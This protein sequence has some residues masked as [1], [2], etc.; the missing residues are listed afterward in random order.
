[1]SLITH[2][3]N[4]FKAVVLV[5]IILIL[6]A[7]L[8]EDTLRIFLPE[9]ETTKSICEVLF[10]IPTFVYM[11]FLYKL[12]RSFEY[13]TRT[14]NYLFLILFG[15][16]IVGGTIASPG[17]HI[18]EGFHRRFILFIVQIALFGTFSKIIYYTLLEIF[19]DNIPVNER[20][21]GCTCV[22]LMVAITFTSLYDM[23]SLIYPDAIGITHHMRMLDYMHNLSYSIN[24]I[25]ALDSAYPKAIPMIQ[26]IS[27]VEAAWSH[28]FALILVGRLL[29]K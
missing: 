23:V 3:T 8:I 22:F 5:Q 25:G 27:I 6:E 21:W 9:S 29:S 19:E 14:V 16:F 2:K 20:L 7:L 17:M 11:Y 28:I 15:T 4:Y 10:I 24:I 12:V 13:N 18:V 26:H 1:M